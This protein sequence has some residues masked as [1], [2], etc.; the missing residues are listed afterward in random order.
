MTEDRNTLLTFFKA[1]ADESRLKIVGLLAQHERS[2]DE[3]A[4]ALDLKAPTVSHHLKR[5]R[6]A[7]LVSMRPDG[8]THWYTLDTASLQAASKRIL[9]REQVASIADDV[10][11]SAEERKVLRTFFEGKTLVSLPRGRKREIVLRFLA[12]RFEPGRNYAQE[13]VNEILAEHH[14]DVAALRRWLVDHG[15]LERDHRTYRRP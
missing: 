9:T 8:T 15:L 14:D 5:L 10:D 1:L 3:L 11:A 4:D 12:D 6:D 13:E 2:V 7:G